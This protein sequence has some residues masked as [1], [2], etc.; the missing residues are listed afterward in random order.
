M[1][2]L[3]HGCVSVIVRRKSHDPPARSLDATLWIVSLRGELTHQ[4][5]KETFVCIIIGA[6]KIAFLSI[7]IVAILVLAQQGS[8]FSPLSQCHRQNHP[9]NQ[10]SLSSTSSSVVE[11]MPPPSSQTPTVAEIREIRLTDVNGKLVRLGDFMMTNQKSVIVFMR[12]L[13]CPYCWSYANEIMQ[14]QSRM[15][16]ANANGPWLISIGD[17]EKLDRFLEMNPNIPKSQVFVD[18]YQFQAYDTA[19]F[20][21]KFNDDQNGNTPRLTAPDLGGIQGWWKYLTNAIALAPIEKDQPTNFGT[22]PE[23]VLRMGGTIVVDG[24][25]I[26]YQWFDNIPGDHPNLEDV[27]KIVEGK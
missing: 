15:N 14:L 10:W 21:K 23:G 4:L 24:D 8:A 26:V 9:R 2:E 3:F 17:A 16:A 27:M 19:G 13:G 7:A 25:E 11:S 18:D 6:M 12:H 5:A 22:I 20:T 1:E